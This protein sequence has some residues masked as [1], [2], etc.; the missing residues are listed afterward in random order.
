M[1]SVLAVT[2]LHNILSSSLKLG[3][4]NEGALYIPPLPSLKL[5][6]RSILRCIIST[7]SALPLYIMV[8]HILGHQ[9]NIVLYQNLDRI[10]HLNVDCYLMA[11]SGLVRLHHIGQRQQYTLTT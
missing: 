6:P 1:A 3:C 8:D 7:T 2:T 4:D 5:K 10:P 9:D 11:K